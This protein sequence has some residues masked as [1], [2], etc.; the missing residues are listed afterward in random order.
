MRML[1]PS[2]PEDWRGRLR[3][4]GG[5]ARQYL[6]TPTRQAIGRL[7]DAERVPFGS[8]L[9]KAG[10]GPVSRQLLEACLWYLVI[11]DADECSTLEAALALHC[12]SAGA[13]EIPGGP[14]AL[15][16]ALADRF[17]QDGGE[18]R[19]ETEVGACLLERGRVCG[20][21]TTAGET[22]R[23]RFVVSDVP[24]PILI[25]GLLSKHRS[26]LFRG[27]TAEEPRRP[28]AVA[29][30]MA[31]V[32]PETFLPSEL[33]SH[34]LVVQDAGLPATGENLA[35]IRLSPG[36]AGGQTSGDLRYLTVGR[37]ASP[38]APAQAESIGRSLL[39]AA[40]QIAPGLGDVTTYRAVFPPEKLGELLGRPF[41]SV[42]YGPDSGVWWGARGLPNQ[43][44]WPGLLAVGEWTQPGRLISHIVD[45]AIAVSDSIA[46]AG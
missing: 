39:S 35:F 34:C 43:T 27:R 22:V 33:G 44:G 11:R 6:S 46:M 7:R 42:R 41:A 2:P 8:T 3:F 20:V 26:R 30:A 28:L 12:L 45:G 37:F 1:P 5:L 36:R 13:M 16:N 31:L 18:I 21:V 4:W 25:Q 17:R 14:V 32:L 24:P 19:L 23:A 40:E 10:L 29:Q 15:A 38:S 9:A